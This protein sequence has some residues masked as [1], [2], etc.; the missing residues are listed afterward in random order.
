M[1][2]HY[3][4]RNLATELKCVKTKDDS[5][6]DTEAVGKTNWGIGPVS[7]NRGPSLWWLHC[8]ACLSCEL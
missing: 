8:T 4:N 2:K 3:L 5:G 6:Q 7:G 1:V